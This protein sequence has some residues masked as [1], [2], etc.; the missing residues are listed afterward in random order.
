MMV[1]RLILSEIP[2]FVG[3]KLIVLTELSTMWVIKNF[4]ILWNGRPCKVDLH[5]SFIT[6]VHIFYIRDMLVCCSQV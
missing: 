5:C 6:L 2:P 4:G 3:N 1:F